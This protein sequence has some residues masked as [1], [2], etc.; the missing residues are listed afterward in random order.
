M[1]ESD[2]KTLKTDSRNPNSTLR[3]QTIHDLTF[4]S[5]FVYDNGIWENG[6]MY[7]PQSGKY[8][9]CII[10]LK[11]ETLEIRS[12]VGIPLLGRSTYWK[13]MD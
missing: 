5:D 9:S 13:K 7:D 6:K 1:V 11:E 3:N 2:G 12:F 10:R 4:L 8:Y